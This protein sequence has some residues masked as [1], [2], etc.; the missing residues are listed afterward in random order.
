[1]V[2]NKGELN[3]RRAVISPRHLEL[4]LRSGWAEEPPQAGAAGKKPE[5]AVPAPE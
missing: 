1:M 3:E 2:K 4:Y 5:A